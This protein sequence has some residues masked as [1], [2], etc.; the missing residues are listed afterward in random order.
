[1]PTV[2]HIFPIWLN[3][4]GGRGAST[5]FGAAIILVG[6]KF[7]LTSFIIWITILFL[8]RIMSLTN[9]L[10]AWIFT[11]LLLIYFPWY[12]L[13]GLLGAVLITYALRDNIKRLKEGK[14]PKVS[15]KW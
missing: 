11:L 2:G 3:F 7:L 15:F 13:Y 1:M 10:F 9:L 8:F 14:E 4:K 6:L 5:F 12:F